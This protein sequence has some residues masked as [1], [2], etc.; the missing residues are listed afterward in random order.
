[1]RGI[2]ITAALAAASVMSAAQAAQVLQFDLNSLT[3]TSSSLVSTGFTGTI[4]L[5]KDANSTL[6]A[7]LIDGV[8][9]GIAAGQL[10]AVTGSITLSAGTVT[11]G[12]LSITDTGGNV[13]SAN[14]VSGSGSVTL[15]AGQTG[16]FRIDGLTFQGMFNSNTFA[17]VD[18]SPWNASEPL[19][20]SFL[21][22]KFGQ[23]ANN[24]GIADSNVDTDSDID[25]FVIVPTPTAAGL[26]GLG[27]L[28]LGAVRRRR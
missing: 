3:A 23:D 11:G 19:N 7:I 12:S 13:Y 26:A 21:Q 5:S 14:I 28:G 18:V 10:L 8:D 25:V 1:M 22:F 15:S 27:L 4:T 2:Q 16:P 20:G 9:Q 6:N 17:G 24:D